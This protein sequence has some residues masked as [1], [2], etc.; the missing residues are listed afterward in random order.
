MGDA[1]TYIQKKKTKKNRDTHRYSYFKIIYHNC[2]NTLQKKKTEKIFF[3]QEKK[4]ENG[5]NKKYKR[6]RTQ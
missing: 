2:V 4:M 5:K 3:S 1:S 6:K